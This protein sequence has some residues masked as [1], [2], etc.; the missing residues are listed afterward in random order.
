MAGKRT[1]RV[2]RPPKGPYIDVQVWEPGQ[3][4]EREI[5]FSLQT[6]DCAIERDEDAHVGQ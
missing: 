6:R 1:I 3:L 4:D 2:R 5:P